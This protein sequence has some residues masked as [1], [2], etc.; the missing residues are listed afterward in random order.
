MISVVLPVY[1]R[2]KYLAQA[3][4]SIL[5]QTYENFELIVWD[6]GSTD[7]S[8][9][10]ATYYADKD[11]RII[12]VQANHQ[13]LTKSLKHA[14][15]LSKGE[16]ICQ[17]DSDDWIAPSCLEDTKLILDTHPAVGLTYTYYMDVEGDSNILTLGKRCV[18]PYSEKTLLRQHIVF[19][20]RLMRRTDFELVGGI[21]EQFEYAQDYDLVLRLSEITRFY[22]LEKPLYYHRLHENKISKQFYKEQLQ[23]SWN[24]INDAIERRK[25]LKQKW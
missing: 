5:A 15:Y 20:F 22:K 12:L 25:K 21:N 19:H 7:N 18:I 11:K 17:V 24:A 23:Y 2:E 16:Y 8:L 14:F 6:D 4:K 13:G 10:I 3:I 1:N 9:N